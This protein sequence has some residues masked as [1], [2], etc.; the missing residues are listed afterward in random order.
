MYQQQNIVKVHTK[1]L[2]KGNAD[3]Y[4]ELIPGT[5]ANGV[6]NDLIPDTDILTIGFP[7]MTCKKMTVTCYSNDVEEHQFCNVKDV[8][9]EAKANNHDILFT[10]NN[11]VSMDIVHG[12]GITKIKRSHFGQVQ[13]EA[14]GMKNK[15][16]RLLICTNYPSIDICCKSEGNVIYL[17]C[18]PLYNYSIIYIHPIVFQDID[19]KIFPEDEI[20][21][22]ITKRRY[23]LI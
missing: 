11:V 10:L 12:F 22:F 13:Y 7:G 8:V 14:K 17:S 21:K 20:N 9:I 5:I 3:G 15:D 23:K 16:P 19:S 18:K 2:T 6:G 1:G 4:I